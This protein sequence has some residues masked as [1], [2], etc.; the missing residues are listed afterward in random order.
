VAQRP[1]VF[2]WLSHHPFQADALLAGLLTVVGVAGE[3]AVG[4][5]WAGVHYR[6]PDAL[7]LLLSLALTV[8]L[9]W[10]RRHP[11]EV[12]TVVGIATVL[13]YAAHYPPVFVGNPLLL[14]FYSAVVHRRRPAVLGPVAFTLVVVTA[15]LI[16]A[17]GHRR[18]VELVGNLVVLA[19]AWII[20][21]AVRNRRAYRASLVEQAAQ[22]ELDQ[23][24]ESRQAVTDERARIARELHD[25]VAHSMS[26]MVVQAGAARRVIDANPHQAKEALTSIEETGRQALEEMR[27]LVGVLRHDEDSSASRWPQPTVQQLDLLIDNLSEAGL[28]VSLVVEGDAQ[29]LPTGVDLS[30]FRIVQEALTNTLKHAGQAQARVVL[31]WEAEALEIE[32]TDDG[33]GPVASAGHVHGHGLVGMRERVALFNGTLQAGPGSGGGF[34]V[35][36]RFPLVPA[37]PARADQR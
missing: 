35:R 26:V 31:R 11:P 20:G 3:W 2:A 37:R 33:R 21:D 8:P 12:L 18:V 30:A 9:A 1:H 4:T 7:A 17:R 15:D 19:L 27:R 14:A 23:A 10:R 13:I 28:D 36:A 6:Q 5:H 32:I 29:P 22:L 16:F 24:R 25:V 34:R